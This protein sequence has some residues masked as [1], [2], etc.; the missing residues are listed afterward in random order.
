[1][2]NKKLLLLALFSIFQSNFTMDVAPEPQ[3]VRLDDGHE[4]TCLPGGECAWQNADA[5]VQEQKRCLAPFIQKV[6]ALRSGQKDRVIAKHINKINEDDQ[7]EYVFLFNHN[8]FDRR[9]CYYYGGGGVPAIPS[10][11]LLRLLTLKEA[12]WWI[13]ALQAYHLWPQQCGSAR[14]R[15]GDV[16]RVTIS[17]LMPSEQEKYFRNKVLKTFWPIQRLLHIARNDSGSPLY[18]CP[19]DVVRFITRKTLDSKAHELMATADLNESIVPLPLTYKTIPEQEKY[20]RKKVLEEFQVVQRI[21]YCKKKNV[22]S[23]L[24]QLSQERLCFLA[25][26]I[27]DEKF[28]IRLSRAVSARPQDI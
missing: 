28:N 9:F 11:A 24:H 17:N 18:R 21:L 10:D 13:E 1:M 8:P 4:W 3:L 7:T 14:H 6:V 5:F 19:K 23:P 16:T 15:D 22:E 25:W 27:Y 2:M 12:H 20:F 26:C